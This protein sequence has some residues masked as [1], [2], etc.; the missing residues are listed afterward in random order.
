M[1]FLSF[2]FI[3]FIFCLSHCVY[4]WHRF[5]NS[6]WMWNFYMA[7]NDKYTQTKDYHRQSMR[8]LLVQLLDAINNSWN[9]VTIA[10]WN[11]RFHLFVLYC[12]AWRRSLHLVV[13]VC[14]FFLTYLLHAVWMCSFLNLLDFLTHN[15][16]YVIWTW[17]M[18]IQTG[19]EKWTFFFH[20]NIWE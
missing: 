11:I 7:T 20:W 10:E 4:E 14:V 6:I 8:E 19:F 1:H 17:K 2:C 18:A 5:L 13:F 3:L 16:I 9:S 15:D 12:I